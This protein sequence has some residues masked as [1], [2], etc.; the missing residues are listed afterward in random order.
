LDY[1]QIVTRALK[2]RGFTV[3]LAD[4]GIPTAVIGPISRLWGSYTTARSSATS[5]IRRR[6][7]SRD[8]PYEIVSAAT[9][10]T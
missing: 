5:S 7:L 8:P 3:T 10:A 6:R 4:L 1:P 9:T 2:S